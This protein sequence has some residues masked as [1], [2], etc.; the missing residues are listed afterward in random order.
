MIPCVLS[1]VSVI[2]TLHTAAHTLDVAFDLFI[3]LNLTYSCV[4]M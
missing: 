1:S 3:F 2:C 4:D